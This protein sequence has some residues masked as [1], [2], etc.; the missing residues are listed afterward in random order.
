MCVYVCVCALFGMRIRAAEVHQYDCLVALIRSKA[1][2]FSS[3]PQL[4][5]GT[6]FLST[7]QLPTFYFSI[8]F[9]TRFFFSLPTLLPAWLIVHNTLIL[10]FHFACIQV[11]IRCPGSPDLK[12]SGT[13]S[14]VLMGPLHLSHPFHISSTHPKNFSRT[15][16]H[17][18]ISSPDTFISHSNLAWCPHSAGSLSWRPLCQHYFGV[19]P[20]RLSKLNVQFESAYT[21]IS[22]QFQ[23]QWSNK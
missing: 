6:R 12:Y 21:P 11:C 5:H 15:K 19:L 10:I 4:S 14:C 17:Y 18:F 1:C 23:K 7:T 13:L 2:F 20:T 9:F 22:W 3:L 16:Q 8:P